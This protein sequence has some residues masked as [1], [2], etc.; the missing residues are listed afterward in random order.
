MCNLSQGILQEGIEQGI[1]KRAK[2]MG[3]AY[4]KLGGGI[5]SRTVDIGPAYFGVNQNR[6]NRVCEKKSV[7][8]NNE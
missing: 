8:T 1:V 4:E 6:P 7:K 2:E 5:D 3:H